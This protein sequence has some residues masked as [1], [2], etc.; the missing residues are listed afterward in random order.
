M[1]FGHRVYRTRD[2]RADILKGIVGSLD[3]STDGMQFAEA[4]ERAVLDALAAKYEPPA[5]YECRVLH[6]G[7]RW[8]RP[9]AR[10]LY[11]GLRHGTGFG[12]CAISRSRSRV[13]VSFAALAIP[14][15]CQAQSHCRWPVDLRDDLRENLVERDQCIQSR[16]KTAIR[17]RLHHRLDDFFSRHADERGLA[18]LLHLALKAER[19]ERGQRRNHPLTGRQAGSMPEPAI[20]VLNGHR[21]ERAS[22]LVRGIHSLS[23]RAHHVSSRAGLGPYS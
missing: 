16:W 6:R 12:W 23:C 22:R 2:P 1:G 13:D 8:R 5:R 15:R 10:T 20:A 19:C 11:L 7:A 3:Q 14:E 4:L 9:T 21:I 17:R 18:K